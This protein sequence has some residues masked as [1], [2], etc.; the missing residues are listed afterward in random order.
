MLIV[1]EKRGQNDTF[2]EAIKEL[3]QKVNSFRKEYKKK[4]K[5]VQ[6]CYNCWEEGHLANKCNNL[7]KTYKQGKMWK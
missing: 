2:L 6:K 7:S 3:T 4:P 5:P 1:E